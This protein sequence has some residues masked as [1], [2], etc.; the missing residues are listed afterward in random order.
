MVRLDVQYTRCSGQRNA[1]SQRY[2]LPVQPSKTKEVR[3]NRRAHTAHQRSD[4]QAARARRQT[5]L[6]RQNIMCGRKRVQLLRCVLHDGGDCRRGRPLDGWVHGRVVGGDGGG[7][8]R[9]VD[10][11]AIH[12]RAAGK[13]DGERQAR[14]VRETRAEQITDADNSAACA[15]GGAQSM[16]G[17]DAVDDAACKGDFDCLPLQSGWQGDELRRAEVRVD[18][19]AQRASRAAHDGC[20]GRDDR[21]R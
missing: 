7:R 12:Q 8:R 11:H 4:A 19:H 1:L 16:L 2:A 20:K 14:R 10:A 5:D 6:D 9:K 3:P 17:H 13:R 15:D 18:L 21:W